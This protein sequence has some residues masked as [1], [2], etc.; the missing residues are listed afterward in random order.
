MKT[1]YAD[2]LRRPETSPV[3]ASDLSAALPSRAEIEAWSTS[4][5]QLS[6]A[7]EAFGAAAEE[8]EIAA[9]AHVQE[10]L[11]PG[12]SDWEGAAADA[13]Q[14]QGFSDRGVVYAAAELMQ[15]IRKVASAGAGT[16]QNARD[17]AL[18][19]ISEAEKDDFQVRDDLAVADTRRYSAQQATI[20]EPQSGGRSAP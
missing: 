4:I 7:A 20:R 6:A 15:R 3:A 14:R 1:T 5:E 2:L 9:D 8:I 13:A 18:D 10:L 19:A 16:I 12:D 11:K 17:L